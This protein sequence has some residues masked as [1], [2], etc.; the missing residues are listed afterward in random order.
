MHD[1][2]DFKGAFALNREG[3]NA[4]DN[5]RGLVLWTDDATA[6]R[7]FLLPADSR[8]PVLSDMFG[9]TTPLPFAAPGAVAVQ[10]SPDP[11]FV[12]WQSASP[13]APAIQNSPLLTPAAWVLTPGADDTLRVE[14]VNIGDTPLDAQISVEPGAE[15]GVTAAPDPQAVN[16]APGQ[17]ATAVFNVATQPQ[18]PG[19]AWPR[20][21]RAFYNLPAD[22]DPGAV[23]TLPATLGGVAGLDLASA[24]NGM[25]D[26]A[27]HGGGIREKAPVLLFAEIGAAADGQYRMG[28]ASD[29]WMEWFVNG[30][31]VYDTLE[32]GNVGGRA[33][34]TDHTFD[35]PLNKGKNIIA[36]RV[37]SGSQGWKIRGGGPVELDK[38]GAIGNPDRLVNIILKSPEG[39][40]LAQ[41]FAPV[42]W[43]RRAADENPAA[44]WRG[45]PPDIEFFDDVENFFVAEPDASKWWRGRDDLSAAAWFR[46]DEENLI[47]R[48]LVTDDIHRPPATPPASP[49]ETRDD[50]A[51]LFANG[52]HLAPSSA[53]REGRQTLYTFALPRAPAFDLQFLILDNDWGEPKQTLRSPPIPLYLP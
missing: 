41:E 47:V 8:D 48:L 25:I 17:R 34:I 44:P 50:Y 49:D 52:L 46:A 33:R 26:L 51:W 6:T 23:T 5:R 30:K 24:A 36:V 20:Q 35:L 22:F 2:A 16:V 7:T 32:K 28:A 37:L 18:L 15:S 40:L 10:L 4:P 42:Q 39:V 53:T 13:A 45:L 21:W 43:R 19:I 31:P 27:A 29:W 1:P 14:L 38:I 11:V 12:L 3:K 9:N